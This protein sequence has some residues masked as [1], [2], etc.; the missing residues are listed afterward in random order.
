[1]DGTSLIMS[2][3]ILNPELK[4]NEKIDV[5]DDEITVNILKDGGKTTGLTFT[6]KNIKTDKGKTYVM[7]YDPSRID[8]PLYIL[9]G[10]KT[11]KGVD[12]CNDELTELM[13]KLNVKLK[14]GG[15]E[16]DIKVEIEPP[17]RKRETIK[18]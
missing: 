4:D 10:G 1:M 13:K 18:F 9:I 12:K 17:T 15:K 5:T 14:L 6:F 8:R 3:I 7:K 11:G 16:E 2:K